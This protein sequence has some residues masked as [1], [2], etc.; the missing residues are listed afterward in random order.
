MGMKTTASAVVIAGAL[1]AVLAWAGGGDAA[2]AAPAE[3]LVVH[4]WGTFTSVAGSDGITLEGIQREEEGLPPFVYDRTKVRNCPFRAQGY[5]GLEVPVSGATQKMETPV[6][7][8]H[9]AARRRVRVR[10]D[11]VRGLLTQWY[12][13]TDLL[14]PPEGSVEKGPLDLAKVD[15]SFL[16]W[17]VDLLP[18]ESPAF[19]KV[20]EGDPWRFARAVDAAA[21]RTVPRP[22][23]RSGPVEAERFLFYRGLG[24]FS[25]PI[26]AEA[27]GA[28]RT[29]LRNGAVE[30]LPAAFALEIGPGG[31]RMRA[32]G[33]VPAGS[34]VDAGLGKCA[35]EPVDGVVARLREAVAGAL[36][37]QGLRADEAKAMVETW[38]RS[39]FRS[40]GTRILYLVPRPCVDA[41][42]PMR[43]TPAPDSLV[44]VLVGRIEVLTPEVEAEAEAALRDR[45]SPE[46]AARLARFDRFLEP[47]ARRVL[48][49][50][51]DEAARKGAREL[52]GELR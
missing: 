11:F 48:A 1:T 42:L 40:E 13:V 14:G 36:E 34:T 15:R 22:E 2:P 27:K 25:L 8:F 45:K 51:A 50:T 3:P 39:W 33:A 12:P 37:A 41:I 52:L 26:D 31:A 17:E 9:T 30:P 32:L 46:S 6:I 24:T 43:I 21:V 18:G 28:A 16:E 47:V 44:R 35:L 4:E 29:A 38:S 5:K 10:V 23:G 19:P 20:G 7:Y 49:R